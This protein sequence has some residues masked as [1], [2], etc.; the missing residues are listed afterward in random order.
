MSQSKMKFD[1]IE[2]KSLEIADHIRKNNKLLVEVLTNYETTEVAKD[3]IERTLD[4]L[5]NLK[6]NSSYFSGNKIESCAAFLPSNQ[7]LYALFCFVVI[8][9]FQ[10]KTAYVR[11]PGVMRYFFG[12]LLKVLNFYE[13][14][15]SVKVLA[16]TQGEYLEIITATKFSH[17]LNRQVPN[18]KVVIFTGNPQ[19]IEKI[20]KMIHKETL[21]I[22]NGSGHNPIVVTKSA[23]ISQAVK[24]VVRLQLYNQGQDCAAPNSI[25]VKSTTY[26]DFIKQLILSLEKVVV[27]KYNTKGVSVGP[28]TKSSNLKNITNFLVANYQW[29]SKKRSAW[30]D[31]SQ[32]LI[33][34]ILVEKPLDEGGQL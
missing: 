28:T 14:C 13:Y 27:G 31:F 24:S 30:I 8:P 5:E 10:S 4:L 15:P 12:E 1:S 26:D 7:P 9:S 32:K 16:I 29:I 21:F 3:E 23:N 22:G 19:N 17:T 34:P 20:K 2:K 25:L 33:Y 11:V 18:I 6:E